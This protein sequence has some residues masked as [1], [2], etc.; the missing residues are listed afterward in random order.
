MFAAAAAVDLHQRYLRRIQVLLEVSS[1]ARKEV[2]R[3]NNT[4]YLVPCV[5]S[6]AQLGG[7]EGGK[8]PPKCPPNIFSK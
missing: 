8:C 7:G 3:S 1:G 2:E 4:V 6:Q 5:E